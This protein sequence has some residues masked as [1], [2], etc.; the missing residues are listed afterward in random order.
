MKTIWKGALQRFFLTAAVLIVALLCTAQRSWQQELTSSDYDVALCMGKKVYAG[1]S[2]SVRVII[3][4]KIDGACMPGIPVKIAL[5]DGKEEKAHFKGITDSR[6]TLSPLL[7]VP[8]RQGR[9]NLEITVGE[10]AK[11]SISSHQ[12]DVLRKDLLM[13][14]G[15]LKQNVSDRVFIGRIRLMSRPDFAGIG[16]ERL[17][18]EIVD[19]KS[20]F[21]SRREV[22][23]D[24]RGFAAVEFQL[25]AQRS[26]TVYELRV[27]GEHA[28]KSRRFVVPGS[29]S[30]E[31]L[32][33][34][35]FEKT[36]L[37]PGDAIMG[38][39]QASYP[40]GRPAGN[41]SIE[42]VIK[43]R[44]KT[45][46]ILAEL[47]RQTDEM[48]F[49]RFKSQVP[50]LFNEKKGNVPAYLIFQA[51]VIKGRRVGECVRALPILAS[52]PY[53]NLIPER[54]PL[55]KG[56]PSSFTV[57]SIDGEGAP[58]PLKAHLTGDGLS[59]NI[60]PALRG[61]ASFETA[62]RDREA[63]HFTLSAAYSKGNILKESFNF[64]V[65]R[66]LQS[67]LIRP[68]RHFYIK[69][70]ALK[71]EIVSTEKTGVVYLDFI[72]D[73][74]IMRT[75]SVDLNN[76]RATF[77]V[78]D[79]E[80]FVGPL[81]IKGSLLKGDVRI[82]DELSVLYDPEVSFNI[83]VSSLKNRYIP[84]EILPLELAISSE[85]GGESTSQSVVELLLGRKN[86]EKSHVLKAGNTL[87]HAALEGL[88][89]HED[90]KR[91]AL[92]T[93]ITSPVGRL[94]TLK[95]KLAAL[96]CATVRVES[97]SFICTLPRQSSDS[98]VTAPCNMIPEG[99]STPR[100]DAAINTLWRHALSGERG[101]Q[102]L[103]DYSGAVPMPCNEVL[104]EKEI[105][106][107]L[108]DS[109]TAT[110]ASPETA[111]YRISLSIPPSP[112]NLERA[113]EVYYYEPLMVSGKDGIIRRD[114][115][116]PPHNFDGELTVR[117]LTG[118]GELSHRITIFQQLLCDVPLLFTALT[119][120]DRISLP[121]RLVNYCGEKRNLSVEISRRPWFELKG[122]RKLKTSIGAYEEGFMFFNLDILVTGRQKMTVAASMGGAME[123]VRGEYEVLP[124]AARE[125]K[126]FQGIERNEFTEKI[127]YPSDSLHEGR[128][129]SLV[130][131]QGALS[132]IMRA[133]Q[134]LSSKRMVTSQALMTRLLLQAEMEAELKK[135]GNTGKSVYEDA[136]YEDTA[137]LMRD[138]GQGG[139]ISLL[140]GRAPSS[141]ETACAFM[142]LG[143]IKALR[144]VD[145]ESRAKMLKWLLSKRSPKGMWIADEASASSLSTSAYV[146]WALF[147]GGL[148]VKDLESSVLSLREDSKDSRDPLILALMLEIE[149]QSGADRSRI[150]A[151]ASRLINLIQS[152]GDLRFWRASGS[153]GTSPLPADCEVTAR[154]VCAL[155]REK[156]GNDRDGIARF[157]ISNQE[158]DGIWSP[159]QSSYPALKA[160]FLIYDGEGSPGDIVLNV[161]G[162]HTH[163]FKGGGG[164][165][166]ICRKV[167]LSE[168]LTGDEN[169]LKFRLSGGAP[170]IYQLAE[171]YY[172]PTRIRRVPPFAVSVA[173]R[174]DRTK[175][176][177]GDRVRCDVSW[178][179][180][181]AGPRV[182]VVDFPVPWGF[183]V[184][185]EALNVLRAEGVIIDYELTKQELRVFSVPSSS[186]NALTLVFTALFPCKVAARP[187]LVYDY[188]C[189]QRRGSDFIVDLEV[190]Q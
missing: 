144:A 59:E 119:E 79:R 190:S 48:G 105:Y 68:D 102:L 128:S 116:L 25:P 96:L 65:E 16:S 126:T 148:S 17:V 14:D 187:V 106:R 94:D 87:L 36:T 160:L 162:T 18:A 30:D 93:L 4:S 88:P 26:Q 178:N 64:P 156:L 177:R 155:G 136:I 11:R 35:S 49:Y 168:Y 3:R 80:R 189:P 1:S 152:K 21:L 172:I 167:D 57:I 139:G 6:G 173:R 86:R 33:N 140:P 170:L 67:L 150:D 81:S 69:G 185:R 37:M 63:G 95:E 181:G 120:R 154:A 19:S 171:E 163:T 158:A 34:L 42:L 54:V 52:V 143:K 182:M 122:D 24:P 91:E 60:D 132:P 108:S 123:E 29:L 115:P 166:S 76:G 27:R 12:I 113:E 186:D 104:L 51:K 99:M 117:A 41:A 44:D 84:G 176:K 53:L 13:L 56:I 175:M 112:P 89:F 114:I 153:S 118:N 71:L 47:E 45:D 90:G 40:D 127:S 137:A 28:G 77:V 157:L 145:D 161:N 58:F 165:E 46:R 98:A 83:K 159:V 103:S 92:L 109:G 8:G 97:G 141:N 78:T 22:N 164:R 124:R 149:R 32:L 73:D 138:F 188:D 85:H 131:Y 5:L 82:G 121:V 31:L 74:Q 111:P 184:D 62:L 39:V 183:R 61:W 146:I 9:M 169:I 20:N 125:L 142:T 66:S 174:F 72:A 75:D 107:A 38:T 180:F 100:L 23:T 129:L 134:A 147:E 151:L 2:F 70:E 55:K 179:S 10:G 133:L 43:A 130:L 7:S 101:R 135:S 15:V 50:S 110:S